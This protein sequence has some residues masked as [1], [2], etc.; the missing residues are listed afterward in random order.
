MA[1]LNNT[2]AMMAQHSTP[3][4]SPVMANTVASLI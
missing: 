2:L 4:S 3:V 1:A